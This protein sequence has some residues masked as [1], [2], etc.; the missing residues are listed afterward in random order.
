MQALVRGLA[1]L[2]TF[3]RAH[4]T[5]TVSEAAR[6][7]GTSRPTA[8]RSLLTLAAVGYVR[9]EG[10]AFAPTPKVLDLGYS[11]VASLD[12]T[13]L[14]QPEMERL[15]A[16]T[17]ESCSAAVLDGD[18]IVYVARV[19]TERIMTI[20]LGI[21]TRLPAHCTS[22]GRVLLAALPAAERDAVLARTVLEART[23]RTLTDADALRTEL[24]TV[25]AAGWCIVDQELELGVRSASVP[26]TDGSGRVV[27]ALNL[28]TNASRVPYARLRE[29]L[30][31]ELRAAGR[32][33]SDQLARR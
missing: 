21:G 23:P 17:G 22:M 25:A 11:Y 1:V 16:A 5:L 10:R 19:P 26:L 7:T 9:H 8:R 32:R 24:A 20:A 29:D 4:P 14:V 33:I 18:Q 28:G 27:A 13:E 2:A 12:L 15:V 31:P 6:L 3:S 30:L